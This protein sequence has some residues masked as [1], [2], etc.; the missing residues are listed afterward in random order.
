V[1]FRSNSGYYRGLRFAA[2]GTDGNPLAWRRLKT[3]VVPI[4]HPRF[5]DVR[6]RVDNR[7]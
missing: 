7:R 6:E 5:A 1:L 4:R 3:V 2:N